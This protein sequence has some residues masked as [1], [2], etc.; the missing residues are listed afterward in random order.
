MYKLVTGA[1][2]NNKCCLVFGLIQRLFT[3]SLQLDGQAMQDTLSQ[4][5]VRE[6]LT[7]GN[8]EDHS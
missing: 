6:E 8:A 2:I 3:P 1:Q 5:S 7:K 4:P